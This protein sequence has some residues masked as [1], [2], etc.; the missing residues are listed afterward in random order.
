MRKQIERREASRRLSEG[1]L[2]KVSFNFELTT[3]R[4]VNI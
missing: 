2:D 3:N 4:E 1:Q